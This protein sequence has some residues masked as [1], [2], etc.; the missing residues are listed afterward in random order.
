MGLNLPNIVIDKN[1]KRSIKINYDTFIP[2]IKDSALPKKYKLNSFKPI[3]RICG[4]N[5]KKY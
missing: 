1:F 2:K 4:L 5:S 3:K